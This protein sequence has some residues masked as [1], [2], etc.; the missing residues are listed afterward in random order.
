MYSCVYHAP[1]FG[2]YVLDL[3]TWGCSGINVESASS[4]PGAADTIDET[5][6]TDTLP[7]TA[8]EYGDTLPVAIN[9]TGF[10]ER[11][12]TSP[13]AAHG[14]RSA[15][16]A[17]AYA[18]YDLMPQRVDLSFHNLSYVLPGK[19]GATILRGVSGRADSGHMV[20]I[21]GP[22]GAGK[23]TLIDILA[24]RKKS[25][26]VTGSVLVNGMPLQDDFAKRAG[27][28]LLIHFFFLSRTL[29]FVYLFWVPMFGPQVCCVGGGCL[30]CLWTAM[31][32]RTTILFRR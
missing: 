18:S 8:A 31:C 19:N 13:I 28:V 22:S 17:S 14:P 10:R 11:H 16:F 9:R 3:L 20:A 12:E 27:C 1:C 7:L 24:G 6:P 32:C 23:T 26:K 15:L 5:A 25:G 29:L 21:M 4:K 30:I 2:W